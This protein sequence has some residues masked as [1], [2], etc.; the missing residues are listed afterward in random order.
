MVPQTLKP[1]MAVANST[2]SIAASDASREFSCGDNVVLVGLSKAEFNQHVGRVVTEMG[3]SG[4]YGVGLHMKDSGESESFPPIA[5]KPENLRPTQRQV[6]GQPVGVLDS[7]GPRSIFMLLGDRGWGLPGSA[8]DNV[9]KF[10]LIDRVS[11]AEVS[12]IGCSSSRGDFPLSVVLNECCEEWWISA[13]GSMRQGLGCEYLEFSFGTKPRRVETVAL[14]IPP[15]PYGPLSVRVFCVKVLSSAGEWLAASPHLQTLDRADLQE[16]ALL[17]P[18]DTS[19]MRIECTRN[20]AAGL[21][22][23]ADCIGL[24]QVAFS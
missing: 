7:V 8:L 14:R 11:M 6:L 16:F 12:V 3:E 2:P 22:R 20:A 4:R 19:V 23:V 5:V 10:L 21:T 15:M 13:P 17:P 24:F 1:S 18:V 9:S